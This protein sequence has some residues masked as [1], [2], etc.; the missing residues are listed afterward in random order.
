LSPRLRFIGCVALAGVDE[1]DPA[2][3][4][5]GLAVGDHP[6]EG[7]DTR[8]VEHLLGQGDDGFKLVALDDPAADLALAAAGAAGKQGRAVEDDGSTRAGLVAVSPGA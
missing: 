7:A 3:A 2:L 5:V 1:L 8:V 4:V 6:D